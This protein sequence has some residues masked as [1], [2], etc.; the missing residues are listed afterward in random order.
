VPGD[1][2]R[3]VHGFEEARDLSRDAALTEDAG[4][5]LAV[6]RSEVARRRMRAG[7]PVEVDPGR[8]L[9]RTLARLLPES[10]W[11]SLTVATSALFA[12]GLFAR[13]AT[14]LRTSGGVAASVAAPLLIICVAMTLS[15]RHDRLSLREGVV[16]TASARPSDERGIALPGATPLPEGARVEL[17]DGRGASRRIRFGA[18]EAW[19]ASGAVRELARLD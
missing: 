19:I 3:A 6:V 16:V 13:W 11:A 1:L 14:R 4:R 17:L 18:L 9:S 7:E 12:M 15:A 5:A 8:S 10:T 2:G